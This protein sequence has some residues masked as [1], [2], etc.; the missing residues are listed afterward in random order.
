M[1]YY[2]ANRIVLALVLDLPLKHF[3]SISLIANVVG[4]KFIVSA[5]ILTKNVFV[6]FLHIFN[7]L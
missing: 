7:N 4:L 3:L 1:I 6:G 5:E 2:Q